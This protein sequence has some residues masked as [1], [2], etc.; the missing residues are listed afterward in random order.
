MCGLKPKEEVSEKAS[1]ACSVSVDLIKKLQTQKFYGPDSYGVVVEFEET[2]TIHVHTLNHEL[3]ELSTPAFVSTDKCKTVYACNMCT[4][5]EGTRMRCPLP[6]QE[7]VTAHCNNT[8]L[9][10]E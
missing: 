5:E 6:L 4:W 3:T 9:F 10:S 2:A 1:Y 8:R 7:F